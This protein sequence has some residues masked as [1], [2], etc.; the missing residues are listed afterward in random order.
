MPRVNGKNTRDIRFNLIGAPTY[1]SLADYDNIF[2][3]S[4]KISGGVLSEGTSGTISMTALKCVIRKTNAIDGELCFCDLAAVTN[5]DILTD[6]AL[7]YLYIDYNSGSPALKATTDRTTI[8]LY[9][10]FTIGR[11]YRQGTDIDIVA[12]GVQPYNGYRR[13]HDRLIKKY[14]F[15]WASGSVVSESGTRKLAITAGVWF[16]GNTEIDT[17]ALDTNVTG[18]FSTYYVT[19][20]T[21]TK[22]TGVTQLGNTQYNDTTSGLVT[23]TAN[24][25]ANYWVYQCP[26]GD[27]YVLYG[28]AQYNSLAEAQATTAPASVPTYISANTKL[29]ARITFLKSAT[30]FSAVSNAHIT[31][32]ASGV[33]TTHNQLAG[34]QGGVIDEYYHLTAPSAPST[35]RYRNVT[36]IDQGETSRTAKAL[37][38]DG[39]TPSMDGSAA[40]GTAM[41]VSRRDHVHPTDTSRL[42]GTG[43]G[44]ST[45]KLYIGK[46][47]GSFSLA[48]LTQGTNVTITNGDGTITIAA[49]SGGI[50]PM[51][52]YLEGE[53]FQTVLMFYRVQATSTISE[54]RMTIGTRCVVSTGTGYVKVDV[55]KNGLAS[56]NSIF[57]SDTPMQVASDATASNGVY[58]ATGTLDSGQTSLSAGDVLY[59]V[60]TEVGGTNM[61][62]PGMDLET[63]ISF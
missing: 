11:A 34:L 16:M 25:Y 23:M 40:T 43:T 47:D 17:A 38:D 39:S 52:R 44:T 45:G 49:A 1:K 26:E 51:R 15:D 13:T 42:A 10:Q 61:T 62:S 12:S 35:A 60:I 58:T 30:N 29:C 55:R 20:G 53:L 50:P 4:G 36:A 9:D 21:W 32:I 5:S 59:V 63:V 37:F 2:G 24:K 57:S 31:Y 22:T 18:S 19:T 48:T 54:A 8:H 7:N 14:G 33:A 28:Q 6:N 41:E 56:T 3:A 27:L 46:T